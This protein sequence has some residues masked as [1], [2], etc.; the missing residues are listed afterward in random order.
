MARRVIR[1][2]LRPGD[3]TCFG[4]V[5]SQRCAC[6]GVG[7][8]QIGRYG[9]DWRAA[10]DSCVGPMQKRHRAL[11]CAATP[12]RCHSARSRAVGVGNVATGTK[13]RGA[14]A[15]HE[16][17]FQSAACRRRTRPAR[18]PAAR[19]TSDDFAL[20][21][22]LAFGLTS[23]MQDLQVLRSAHRTSPMPCIFVIIA[24]G[25]SRRRKPRRRHA[26]ARR[27][28]DP[29]SGPAPSAPPERIA[30]GALSQ[31]VLRRRRVPGEASV[32]ISE[33]Q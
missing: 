15:W 27:P 2:R 26:P 8:A 6:E 13:T 5:C 12:L 25:V 3:S 14:C 19:A 16:A 11:Q 17:S 9:G 24:E 31:A 21:R 1:I 33:I 23:T 30:D 4:C 18:Y 32:Q 20:A 29:P 22:T 10:A 28:A 7:P